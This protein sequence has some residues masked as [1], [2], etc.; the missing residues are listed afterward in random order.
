M[1]RIGVSDFKA[2]TLQCRYR[3]FRSFAQMVAFRQLRSTTAWAA[4]RKVVQWTF[5]DGSSHDWMLTTCAFIWLCYVRNRH[6]CNMSW[7]TWLG[8]HSSTS[9]RAYFNCRRLC[10]SR[11]HY[12]LADCSLRSFAESDVDALCKTTHAKELYAMI[13]KLLPLTRAYS[14]HSCETTSKRFERVSK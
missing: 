4:R 8:A 3:S 5:E 9:S 7:W 1:Q 14:P 12:T 6:L 13:C 11:P 10:D 2:L